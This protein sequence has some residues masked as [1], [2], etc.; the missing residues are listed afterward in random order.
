M[1]DKE[2]STDR[3]MSILQGHPLLQKY[4]QKKVI[5]GFSCFRYSYIFLWEFRTLIMEMW[6]VNWGRSST[7]QVATTFFPSKICP[8]WSSALV[9]LVICSSAPEICICPS[10]TKSSTN[11]KINQHHWNT[12]VNHL[13]PDGT[14][15]SE[16]DGFSEDLDGQFTGGYDDKY[17]RED[18][19]F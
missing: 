13:R 16:F 18:S 15:I 12:S 3:W 1:V 19:T 10:L 7:L 17:K 4:D 2:Q 8:F 6:L 9:I 14:V 5:R 11:Q